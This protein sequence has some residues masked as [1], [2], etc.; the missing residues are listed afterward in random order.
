MVFFHIG[1]Q[2]R[3]GVRCV[4]TLY[5]C[6]H[7]TN[8]GISEELNECEQIIHQ[9]SLCS[10]V[11]LFCRGLPSSCACTGVCLCLCTCIKALRAH[12]GPFSCPCYITPSPPS[13]PHQP[14]CHLSLLSGCISPRSLFPSEG[15][16]RLTLLF[17][18]LTLNS[19]GATSY[20]PFPTGQIRNT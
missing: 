6:G 4:R 3:Q 2:I 12:I 10:D 13:L 1:A 15:I 11:V 20:I 18:C 19:K 16:C 7:F 17:A 9:N 8:P 14:P 5:V